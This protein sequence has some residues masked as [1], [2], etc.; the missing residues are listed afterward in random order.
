MMDGVVK[1]CELWLELRLRETGNC[2][3]DRR[4]DY[5]CRGYDID[6]RALLFCDVEVCACD[7]LGHG[8]HN[9]H[10]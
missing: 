4:N 2:M 7:C 9:V 8:V 1:G 6:E 5:A 3:I 10:K